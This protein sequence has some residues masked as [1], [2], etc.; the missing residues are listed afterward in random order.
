[1]ALNLTGSNTALTDV[2]KCQT[3]SISCNSNAQCVNRI[4][5]YECRYSPGYFSNGHQSCTGKLLKSFIAN[6][7]R[8]G[9]NSKFFLQAELNMKVSKFLV[10]EVSYGQLII[11]LTQE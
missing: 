6:R 10:S 9:P 11:S 5:S 3:G 1:M 4:G 2:D 7:N 8:K